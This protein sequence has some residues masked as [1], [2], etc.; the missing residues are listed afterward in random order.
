VCTGTEPLPPGAAL[1]AFAARLLDAPAGAEWLELADPARGAWRFAALRDGRVEACLFLAA[2]T[3]GAGLPQGPA[4]AALLDGTVAEAGRSGLLAG[5]TGASGAGARGAADRSVCVCFGVGLAAL[6]D[7]IVERRLTDEEA[8]GAALGAGTNR[9]S[10]LP[11]IRE[12][13]RDTA[14]ATAAA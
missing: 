6:R 9:G 10:C 13:P 2:G 1:G 5:R 8:V 14:H 7:A 4:L 12:I 3:E 11:E